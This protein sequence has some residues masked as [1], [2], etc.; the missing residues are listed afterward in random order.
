MN[1]AK[2]L[3]NSTISV[4]AQILTMILQ[5][6]NRRIFVMFLDIEYLGYQS[7]FGNVFSILS[8]AELGIGSII[9]F[10]LYREL[11]TDNKQEIGKLMY[12]YKWVYRLIAVVVAMLGLAACVFVPFIVRDSSRGIGYLYIVY[13]LQLASTVAGYFLSYRR[14]IYAADQ[15]EYKTIEIDLFTKIAVQVVQLTLLAIFRNYLMYL[16]MQLGT[17][18]IA[19][20]IILCR[21]NREYPYLKEKY[22]VTWEDIRKRN[23]ISDVRN[24]LVHKIAYAVFSG[25]DNIVVSA[26]CGIRN[27]ALLGNYQ[28]LR[29]S[30]LGVFFYRLLN[31]VQAA[32]GNI[33][34]SDRNKEELWKQFEMFDV[35]SFFFASYISLGFLTF[36]QPAIQIWLGGTEYLLSDAFV[37]VYSLTVYL[38]AVWE[39]VYKYRSVFGDYRQD[40]N[41]MLL[42]AVLNVVISVVLAYRFGVVGVQIGTFFGFFPMAY[43]RIRFVIGYYFGKSVRRYLLR[44]VLLFGVVLF[45]SGVI[46]MLTHDLPVSAAGIGVMFLVWLCVPLAIGLLIYYRNPHFKEMCTYFRNM[47]G[48]AARRLTGEKRNH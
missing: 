29:S 32:I 39:I 12:L 10:H 38:Y 23:M 44:H 26:I 34:Y 19:N 5:F 6:V 37:I 7:V 20:F 17:T 13:F 41:C 43:G 11:V 27:V 48:M 14:T 22:T 1:S 9:S 16:V 46:Y 2:T 42:S 47:A 25:T 18:V 4:T 31:P 21:T 24:F 3:K 28:I 35:F 33:V 36:L 8:V 15:K 30:V 40:R 45:E